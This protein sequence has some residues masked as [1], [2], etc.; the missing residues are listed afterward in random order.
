MKGIK[1]LHH[2]VNI[3]HAMRYKNVC[4][5]Y[6]LTLTQSF[7]VGWKFGPHGCGKIFIVEFRLA[8]VPYC[9]QKKK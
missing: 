4:F 8:K 1:Y 9:V 2:G 6:S 5:V 7:L 3:T